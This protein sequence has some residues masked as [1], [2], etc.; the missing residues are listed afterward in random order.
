MSTATVGPAKDHWSAEQYR[1]AIGAVAVLAGGVL[2]HFYAPAALHLPACPFHQLTGLYCPGCGSTRA[3]HYL[4][5]LDLATA[6]RCNLMFVVF[7]PFLALWFGS[8]ALRAFRLWRGPAPA[9]V[10][11]LP[12]FDLSVTNSWL[13]AAL[14][15]AWGVVRNLPFAFFTIPP[16]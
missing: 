3:L 4:L 13:L 12:V 8:R 11:D 10:F 5:N 14:M 7:L 2:L 1:I 6:L 15:L 16:Q 9:P